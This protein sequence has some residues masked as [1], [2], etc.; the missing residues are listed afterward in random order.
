MGLR[1]RLD[2]LQVPPA[3]LEVVAPGLRPERP[4]DVP[5]LLRHR[6]AV[7]V[8]LRQVDAHRVVLRLVPAGDDVEPRAATAD[9]VDGRHRLRRHDGVVERGV[10]RRERDHALGVR[11]DAGRERDGVEDALVEVRLAAVADPAGDREHEVDARGVAQLRE[12]Q[13]VVPGRLPAILDLRHGHAGRAVRR[14][15]AELQVLAVEQALRQR[16]LLGRD[17]R[18]RW[19]V[20]MDGRVSRRGAGASSRREGRGAGARSRR[21]PPP[22]RR[23][24][25]GRPRRGAPR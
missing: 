22:G 12:P 18:S 6:V 15:R 14:E 25:R 7:V 24:S 4:H 11:E 3:A 17:G 10:D 23:G 21:R 2:A 8:V 9:L 5:P 19:A 20:E 1:V 16:G 13:V